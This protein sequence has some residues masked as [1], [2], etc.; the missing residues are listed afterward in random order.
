MHCVVG[1]RA[2]PSILKPA[3]FSPPPSRPLPQLSLSRPC[4]DALPQLLVRRPT[5]QGAPAGFVLKST[6]LSRHSRQII[7]VL[8]YFLFLGSNIYTIAGPADIY[9]TGKETYLTPAP[10]AFLIW[11]AATNFVLCSLPQPSLP[12]PS[13]PQPNLLFPNRYAGPSSTSFSSERS[14]TSSLRAASRS[15]LTALAGVSPSLAC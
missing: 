6:T 14:S 5:S 10:W 4:D 8:V 9:Y 11:Y 3:T 7:N 2:R 1:A 13:L 12:Q 15:S